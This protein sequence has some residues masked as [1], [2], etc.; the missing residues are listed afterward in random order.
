M[1]SPRARA[2]LL[3]PHNGVYSKATYH[4]IS[5]G[6]ATLHLD[7]DLVGNRVEFDVLGVRRL[8]VGCLAAKTEK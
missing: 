1:E 8:V 7:D 6:A 3:V 2:A 5:S 4:A